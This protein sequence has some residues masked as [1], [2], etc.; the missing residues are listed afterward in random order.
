M[1]FARHPAMPHGFGREADDLMLRIRGLVR[2]H[3]SLQSCGASDADLRDHATEIRRL[4]DQL[5][6]HVRDALRSRPPRE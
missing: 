4:Q 6:E 2:L 3:R 5:S 1:T